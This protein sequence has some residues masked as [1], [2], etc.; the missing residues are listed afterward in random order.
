LGSIISGYEITIAGSYEE[1]VK[2]IWSILEEDAPGRRPEKESAATG[3]AH[4]QARPSA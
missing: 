3:D 2:Q 1:N 4:P